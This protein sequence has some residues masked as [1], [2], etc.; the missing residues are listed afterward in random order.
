MTGLIGIPFHPR[1][2]A[3]SNEVIDQLMLELKLPAPAQKLPISD[4]SMVTR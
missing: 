1:D 4:I 3:D 2:L